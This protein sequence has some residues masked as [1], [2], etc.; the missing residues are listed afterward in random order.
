MLKGESELHWVSS[1]IVHGVES[2]ETCYRQPVPPCCCEK[3]TYPNGEIYNGEWKD[4]WKDGIWIE[5]HDNG[6]KKVECRHKGTMI[7]P[8]LE[9]SVHNGKFTV[10]TQDGK[11]KKQG[12]Y[13]DGIKDWEN[14]YIESNN[15]P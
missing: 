15:N 3:K 7:D 2:V 12:N 10:W 11:I 13:I 14:V 5:W 8:E 1:R 9:R 6:Q 4:G